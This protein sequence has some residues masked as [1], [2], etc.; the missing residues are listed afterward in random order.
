MQTRSDGGDADSEHIEVAVM[1]QARPS[2]SKYVTMTTVV[3]CLR[4]ACRKSSISL[5][6]S[7]SV[8]A[9][10][11]GGSVGGKSL[12]AVVAEPFV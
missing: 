12:L 5:T 6:G 2:P 7:G 3:A 10:A 1:P 4:N 8:G 9:V 11:C